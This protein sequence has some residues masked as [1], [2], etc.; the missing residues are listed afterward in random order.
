MLTIIRNYMSWKALL[1]FLFTLGFAMGSSSLAAD[2]DDM[3]TKIFPPA[4]EVYGKTYSQLT[5]AWWDW[6]LSQAPK[7]NPILDPDGSFCHV[8]QDRD[9]GQGEEIFFLAGNF[10]GETE[11]TCSVPTG[12]TLFFPIL[13]GIWIAPEECATPEECR[14]A[15]NE[16]LDYGFTEELS[17]TIDGV[18]VEDLGAYRV[19]SPP[20]GSLFHIEGGS[21][22]QSFDP[23]FYK[24]RG[25]EPGTVADGYWLLV[26]LGPGEHTIEFSG[27]FFYF[28]D[29][30]QPFELSVKYYLTVEG[31]FK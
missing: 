21:L 10:G 2:D 16:F 19:Q 24:P 13:N 6:A 29:P 12:K 20:G 11:R 17:C 31:G 4:G 15:V 1:V 14:A 27:K 22:L 26:R 9:Y 23:K 3:V 5:V 8:G 28:G 25:Y 18:E 7:R 30:E